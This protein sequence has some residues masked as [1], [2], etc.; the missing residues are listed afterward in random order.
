MVN[1]SASTGIPAI[2][3]P[4]H[5]TPGG[6]GIAIGVGPVVLD[7]Y[8]DFQCP[9]CKQFELT[10]GPTLRGLVAEHAVTRIDHPLNLLDQAPGTGYS[11]RAAAAAAAADD[12]GWYA[13]YA[14]ALLVNQPTEGGPGLDDGQLVRFGQAIGITDLG[15]AEAVHSGRYRPWPPYVTECAIRRG[16]TG[17]PSVLVDGRPVSARP[18]P[19][20]LAVRVALG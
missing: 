15:F 20:E 13:D 1:S 5:S 10:T 9:L 4:R 2:P 3:L 16:I 12:C 18:G 11:T 6:D 17:T 8:L 19:I 14:E 7:V